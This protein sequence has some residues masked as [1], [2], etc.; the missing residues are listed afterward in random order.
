MHKGGD[1]DA[2]EEKVERAH[3][4]RHVCR[5]ISIQY[6]ILKE[7]KLKKTPNSKTSEMSQAITPFHF[8]DYSYFSNFYH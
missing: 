8:F 7:E 6:L 5:M 3:H 2:N 4:V 1:G